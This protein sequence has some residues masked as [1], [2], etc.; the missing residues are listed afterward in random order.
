MIV[1]QQPL[2]PVHPQQHASRDDEQWAALEE[3]RNDSSP[4]AVASAPPDREFPPV[5]GE[6][7]GGEG[8]QDSRAALRRDRRELQEVK[9]KLSESGVLAT[10]KEGALERRRL[11]AEM[12]FSTNLRLG[13]SRSTNGE[14]EQSRGD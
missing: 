4:P 12:G 1:H 3:G 13:A 5:A 2:P 6:V 9:E 11:K 8:E 10:Y 14:A 7:A